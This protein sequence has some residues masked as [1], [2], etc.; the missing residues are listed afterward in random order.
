MLTSVVRRSLAVRSPASFLGG[1]Q[2][3]FIS[4]FSPQQGQN[5]K[6]S[7]HRKIHSTSRTKADVVADTPLIKEE[8]KEEVTSAFTSRLIVTAEVTV[9]KIFP[10]GFGWQTSSV[11]AETHLGYATDSLQ[12]ALT[13]G[14]GDA[15]GVLVGH[16]TYFAAKSL[17]LSDASI[18]MKREFQ[19]G[20]LLGS[21]AFCS[22]SAWQP[23]VDVLQ[24]ANLSFLQVFSGTWVVC[25]TAFYLG[26]RGART[27]L[28]G[29]MEHV[30]EPTYKNSLNDASLSI[31][32]GSATGFFVGTDAV[33]LPDQ[34]FLINVV[35]IQDGT[36][37]LT[38]AAIAGS[39]TALGFGTCQM[40]FNAIFPPGKCWND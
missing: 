9:S 26:L 11:I 23:I 4:S 3:R 17:A 27:I 6:S 29:F 1:Q 15:V 36:G 35:G 5:N 24:G 38:A 20:V 33:Y 12:F 30:H 22:G 2:Y 40:G 39:S 16:T 32:I 13:T 37:D 18:N 21:A 19:T 34:N 8:K 28:S 10:A 14:L 7:H 31:A 25:G